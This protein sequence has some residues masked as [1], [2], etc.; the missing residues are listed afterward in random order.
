MDASRLAVPPLPDHR[1][2]GFVEQ[3][4]AMYDVR[5]ESFVTG[6]LCNGVAT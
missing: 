4:C 1:Y 3:M 6:L 2:Y 5:V